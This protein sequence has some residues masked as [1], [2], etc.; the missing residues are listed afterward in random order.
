MKVFFDLD[1]EE[2][3][4]R[5]EWEKLLDEASGHN[6]ATCAIV[7]NRQSSDAIILSSEPAFPFLKKLSPLR[8]ED[9]ST[10]VWDRSD[11]PVGRMSGLYCSLPKTTFA[12][13]RH[14][15]FCYPITYNELIE[16]FS[17]ADARYDYGFMGGITAP[18]RRK[19]LDHLS[20]HNRL[21]G[22]IKIQGGPW[23]RMFD[24]TGV[25]A[26]VEYAE[27]IRLSKF[28]I[29]PRGNGVGSVRLFEVMKA[30]RVPVIISDNYVLPAGVDWESCSIVVKEGNIANLSEI[31]ARELPRWE[32]LSVNAASTWKTFF[33]ASALTGQLRRMVDAMQAASVLT[34]GRQFSYMSSQ[35]QA[36]SGR[37]LRSAPRRV[38]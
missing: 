15:T 8:Q 35:V 17:P 20:S 6:T 28:V 16:P 12:T 9:V 13:G 19:I 33:S 22:L 3:Y 7:H 38:R 27:N 29:C 25:A 37:A 31:I 26:K 10:F 14:H 21:K 36:A 24:R 5:I 1:A 30:G 32:I 11:H 4:H 2:A 18:L 23:D 34:S